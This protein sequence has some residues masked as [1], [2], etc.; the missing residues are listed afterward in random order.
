MEYQNKNDLVQSF[1][2]TKTYLGHEVINRI[3][4]T[5]F[6]RIIKVPTEFKKYDVLVVQS[7]KK[8][9][10]AVIVKVLKEFVI[11][12]P[13][14][15]SENIHSSVPYKCRFLGEG[16]FCLNYEIIPIDLV[17]ESFVNIFEDKKAVREAIN[18]IKLFTN[19]F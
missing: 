6:E 18:Q 12:I 15:S 7:G 1:T 2:N 16:Y 3:N 19:K 4:N 8:K 17:K 13:L 14:T 9:R 10:P 5:N 11:T